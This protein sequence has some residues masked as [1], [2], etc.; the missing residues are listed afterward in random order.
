MPRDRRV[1]FLLRDCDRSAKS[2]LADRKY[3]FKGNG[4]KN[5]PIIKISRQ[6]LEGIIIQR[7]DKWDA[8]H[9]ACTV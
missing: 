6:S 5:K 2:M 3:S 1:D 7:S 9:H 8:I 4:M